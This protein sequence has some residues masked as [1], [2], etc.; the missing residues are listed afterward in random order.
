MPCGCPRLR[1]RLLRLFRLS[2]LLLFGDERDKRD[3][4]DKSEVGYQRCHCR[5]LCNA[6]RLSATSLSSL[7]SLRSLSSL[8]SLGSLVILRREGQERR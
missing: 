5:A 6:V 8:S 2:G 1:F 7:S 4:R 3:Q